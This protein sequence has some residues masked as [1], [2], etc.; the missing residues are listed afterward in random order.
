MAL[1]KV[2][3]SGIGQVTDIKIGGSGSANTLDDYEEG[4]WTPV[5]TPETQ[6]AASITVDVAEYTKVGR[7]VSI[8]FQIEI[9]S[10]SGGTDARAI[11]LTGMP[12]NIN[13]TA[14]G[15][16]NIG[17]KDINSMTGN[18]ALQGRTATLYRIINAGST[19]SLNASDH[20]KAGSVLSGQFTYH[21]T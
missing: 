14:G 9:N 5:I 3:G 11:E 17:F 2:I 8:V 6:S 4:T 10:I 21:S 15:G 13:S 7:L 20:L 18:F 12:F 16:P 1:T 19:T